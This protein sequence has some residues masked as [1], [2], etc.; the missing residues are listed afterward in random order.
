MDA[1]S[2]AT[3]RHGDHGGQADQGA[4]FHAFSAALGEV[5]RLWR[6]QIDRCVRPL[7]LSFMQWL[8][9]SLLARLGEG[10]VQKDLASAVGIESPT[11]V[12]ILDRLVDAD[13][14]ERRVA[15]NDRRAKT[16]HLTRRG[17]ALLAKS[18]VGL[19]EL[20][21]TLLDGLSESDILAGTRVLE[22]VA[23]R[24]RSL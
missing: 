23:N 2:S 7:G 3:P 4:R 12:G 14:V 11:M 24:A 15:P 1:K 13:L 20:R 8:T 16:V 19:R 6:G 5:A 9:L 17:H 21:E 10:L 22:H 18:E